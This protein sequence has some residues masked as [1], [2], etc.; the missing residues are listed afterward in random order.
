MPFAASFTVGQELVVQPV[1]LAS[2]IGRYILQVQGSQLM[3]GWLVVST[4]V[5]RPWSIVKWRGALCVSCVER[6]RSRGLRGRMGFM[7]KHV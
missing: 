3:F 4:I 6:S 1:D 5:N 2:L 7:R